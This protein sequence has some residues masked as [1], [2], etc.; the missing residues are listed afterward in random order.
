MVKLKIKSM[1][2][3]NKVNRVFNELKEVGK[4]KSK[5]LKVRDLVKF[6]QLHYHG[7][8]AVDFAIKKTKINSKKSV[9]SFNVN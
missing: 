7:T 5:S 3:Y 4:E 6:D 9:F 2:L 1:K 8:K